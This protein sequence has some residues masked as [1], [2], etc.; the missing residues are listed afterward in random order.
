MEV[1]L[2][3]YEVTVLQNNAILIL[4]VV[5]LVVIQKMYGI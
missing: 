5:V 1:E 3:F 4:N 2:A